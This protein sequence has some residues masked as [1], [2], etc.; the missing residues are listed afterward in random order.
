MRAHA[1]ITGVALTLIE[2]GVIS[3]GF[4]LMQT[5]SGIAITPTTISATVIRCDR[6]LVLVWR[7]RYLGHRHL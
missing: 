2:C 6:A 5:I 3:L 4:G 7:C 1:I